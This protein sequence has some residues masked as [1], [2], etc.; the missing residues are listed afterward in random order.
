MLVACHSPQ[1]ESSDSRRRRRLPIHVVAPI[2][3]A[4]AAAKCLELSRDV[5]RGYRPDGSASLHHYV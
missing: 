3:A 4:R 5:K 2:K 1:S